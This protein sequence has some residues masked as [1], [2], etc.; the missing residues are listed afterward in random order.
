MSVV[1]CF[2]S[3]YEEVEALATVDVLRRAGVEVLMVGINGRSIVSSRNISINMDRE[4]DEV[5]WDKIEMIVLPGGIPGVDNLF[6]DKKLCEVIKNFKE[7]EKWIGAICAAPSI[8]GRLGILIGEN[9]TCYPG[10]EKFLEGATV[11][12]ERV[13]KSNK[14]ITGIGAGAS[15]EFAFC[16]LETLKGKQVADEL[17]KAMIMN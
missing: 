1:V 3:G 17:K 15:F 5:E 8:L 10:F 6:A 12:H 9:V 4:L 7:Q 11:T 13:T 2:A 14:I 16:L